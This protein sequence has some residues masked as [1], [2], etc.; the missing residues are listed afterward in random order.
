[1]YDN[2]IIY[3]KK[4]VIEAVAAS[5][6]IGKVYINR[7]LNKRSINDLLDSL[8]KNLIPYS[9]VPLQKLNRLTTNNHQ[10]V[11]AHLSEIFFSSL[12]HLI[13][14]H[15]KNAL[16]VL[17]DGITDTRNMGA[18]IR[19]ASAAK[20]TAVVI[21]TH[22]SAQ[23]T[24]ETVKSSA[25]GVFMIPICRVNHL[26]DAIHLLHSY[27]IKSIAADEKASDYIFDSDLRCPLA[28][29]M[30]SEDKGISNSLKKSCTYKASLPILGD[31]NSY[32]VSVAA[33]M[34]IYEIIRQRLK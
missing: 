15:D 5:K 27:N 3:G 26:K 8:R 18:I 14:N 12:E 24:G 7:D 22:G 29:V 23:I 17:L 19:S 6:S 13:E 11:V 2:K 31:M 25:G 34:F 33:G 20:A 9:F 30:G 21:P 16:F 10:G 1:M 4:P 32:N 28:I